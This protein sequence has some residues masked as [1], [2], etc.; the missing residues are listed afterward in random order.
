MRASLA[1]AGLF[2]RGREIMA[3]LDQARKQLEG[4][5]CRKWA[6]V[7]NN[8]VREGILL[9]SLFSPVGMVPC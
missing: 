3:W 2:F 1:R 7:G 5:Y 4:K 8:W 6:E 9:L